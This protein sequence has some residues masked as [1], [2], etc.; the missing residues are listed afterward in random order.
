MFVSSKL[1][2]AD[3][4][5]QKCRAAATEILRKL[6]VESLDL[7]LLHWPGAHGLKPTDPLHAELRKGSWLEMEQMYKEGKFAAIGVS[8][9]TVRHLKELLTYCSIKPT[10]NQVEFHPYLVQEEL[11]KF[12]KEN[13][14]VLQ[15]YSSLGAADGVNAILNDPVIVDIAKGQ[16]KTTAQTVLRWAL[17]LGIA[18]IPKSS[19]TACIE[20]NSKLFD[21]SLTDQQMAAIS[22]LNKNK[23][24]CWD[25]T[26]VA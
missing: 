19:R 17:Q 18:I 11:L 26:P 23:H 14:I 24:Y 3:Q 6:N 20:E 21:F 9:Y 5:A 4:G 7:F 15:A 10:V 16:Q 2:P 25:P 1:S 8:N 22:G 13:N 12:C